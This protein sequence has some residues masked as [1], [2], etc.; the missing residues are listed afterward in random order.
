VE[1]GDIAKALDFAPVVAGCDCVVH[2]AGRAHVFDGDDARNTFFDTNVAATLALA[3]AAVSAGARRF[4]F[5]SSAG[6]LGKRSHHVLTE[7]DPPAPYNAYTASK[8]EAE[9][10]LLELSRTSGLEVAIVR[11]SMV[12]GPGCPG[13]LRRLAGLIARQIPLPFAL[14]RNRRSVI[15]VDSLAE[16]LARLTVAPLAG[17]DIFLAADRQAVSTPEIIEA[18]AEGLGA[19][20]RLFA[21]PASGLRLAG[22]LSGQ[23]DAVSSLI[24]SHQVDASKIEGKLGFGLGNDTV[25]GVARVGRSFRDSAFSRGDGAVMRP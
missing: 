24:D 13:N 10:Q 1:L 18:L 8:L 19:R 21:F 4:V 25:A 22:M 9:R 16:L 14:V 6:V 5:V 2:L 11:P 3:R 20:A 17:G 7:D 23:A 15:G 12:Y